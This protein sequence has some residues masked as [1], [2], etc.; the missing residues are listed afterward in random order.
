MACGLQGG[1][2]NILATETF[3]GHNIVFEPRGHG[4]EE[5]DSG[6]GGISLERL[7]AAV[8]FEPATARFIS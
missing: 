6:S 4:K 3:R 2:A 5:K 1:C 8:L 7:R